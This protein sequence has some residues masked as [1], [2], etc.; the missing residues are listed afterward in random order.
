MNMRLEAMLDVLRRYAGV[1]RAAWVERK[2]LVPVDRTGDERAFLPAHLELMETPISPAPHWSARIIMLLFALALLWACVG[3]L[4]IVAVAP[5]KVVPTGHTKV[6]QPSETSVVHRILVHDGQAVKK[7]QLLVE[8]DAVGVTEDESKARQALQ[9]AKVDAARTAALVDAMGKDRMPQLAVIEGVPAD[10]LAL[11][12]QQADSE[13][14]SLLAQEHSLRDQVEQ[15]QAELRTVDQTIQPLSDYAAIAQVRVHD[16]E[17]LVDKGYVSKQDYLM[18]KQELIDANKQLVMQRNRR[19]ELASGIKGAQEQLQ[20]TTADARRKLLDEHRK[21]QD[22]IEQL[23]PEVTKAVQRNSFMK[24]RSP[25][26]GTVQQLAINTVGGVVT[27]AQALMQVVPSDKAVEVEA[28]V[29][30]QDIGFVH[31]GQHVAVKVTSFP[32]TRYGYLTGTVESISHDA[33][34]DKKLG[35]IFPAHIHLDST[36][37]DINGVDVE[38]KPGM[39]LNA[40]IRTG[41]R[42]V[43]DYLLSPL[44]THVDEALRER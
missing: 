37:F 40:E 24:L 43:I 3:K 10:H 21:D 17:K 26:D 29:L 42:R 32:Y 35:L 11:A 8:L 19:V 9:S 31:A 27:P 36:V 12:K 22:Q 34:Q 30:N 2:S 13:F 41:K 15:K 7:G 44:E 33:A 18:R 28:T 4:D 25:V 16:Y 6:I 38:V 39:A 20:A 14:L 23:T 1:F 5:G